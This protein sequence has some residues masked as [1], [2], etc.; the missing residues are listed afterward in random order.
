MFS[1][2]FCNTDVK[3]RFFFIA[4]NADILSLSGGGLDNESHLRLQSSEDVN[5]FSSIWKEHPLPIR[6]PAGAGCSGLQ[7]RGALHAQQ[8]QA[9][10]A[11]AAVAEPQWVPPTT[12]PLPSSWQFLS[13]VILPLTRHQGVRCLSFGR[14]IPSPVPSACTGAESGWRSLAQ[15]TFSFV[16]QE[17]PHKP[18]QQC[19]R[20]HSPGFYKAAPRH[21][22]LWQR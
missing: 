13:R 7:V 14:M 11:A 20:F 15:G 4:K 9:A 21:S 18:A 5:T 10:R 17:A 2:L 6:K 3:C 1:G 19:H 22:S 16:D 8:A 12:T